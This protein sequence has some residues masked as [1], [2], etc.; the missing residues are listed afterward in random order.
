ML[1]RKNENVLSKNESIFSRAWRQTYPVDGIHFESIAIAR[2]KLGVVKGEIQYA[3]EIQYKRLISVNGAKLS[4]KEDGSE[5]LVVSEAAVK[6]MQYV[7]DPLTR[8]TAFLGMPNRM[9]DPNSMQS[10]G[11]I[12]KN[13]TGW[14][15]NVSR[16]K[17][18]VNGLLIVPRVLLNSISM[19]FKLAINTAKLGAELLPLLATEGLQLAAARAKT[20]GSLKQALALRMLSWIPDSIYYLA[21]P[22]TSPIQNVRDLWN[23]DRPLEA[24]TSIFIT[25]LAYIFLFPLAVKAIAATVL[26]VVA[27]HLPTVMSHLPG[28][29]ARATSPVLDQ[30]SKAWAVVASNSSVVGLI[31]GNALPTIGNLVDYVA[32][33]F[34]NLL[35][36]SGHVK[37]ANKKPA[38]VS[39]EEVERAAQ[40]QASVSQE[41][42]RKRQEKK[43]AEKDE[44]KAERNRRKEKE[45][46]AK[47][48]AKQLADEA[49]KKKQEQ[50]KANDHPEVALQ[51]EQPLSNSNAKVF[52]ALAKENGAPAPV[53]N[54]AAPVVNDAAPVVND[55]APAVD[56]AAP[57]VDG[58]VIIGNL[59]QD[60]EYTGIRKSSGM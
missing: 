7:Q 33:K 6:A 23:N 60:R 11:N 27:T 20:N 58:G 43:T 48:I 52:Q 26:P 12:F 25:G 49:E 50:E 38:V 3:G 8:L 59:D 19:P 30:L 29:L 44:R 55:A 57:A 17:Q 42:E 22:I 4:F 14:Q 40:E 9:L 10:W 45:A 13:F 15:D 47:K 56:D 24:L 21:R 31:I 39:Q 41:Q 35:R 32:S 2:K 34:S 36:A 1:G 16:G 46:E 37:P 5:F 51:P 28:W 18:V 53:V 54:D